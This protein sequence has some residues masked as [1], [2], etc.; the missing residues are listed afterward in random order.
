MFVAVSLSVGVA[1]LTSPKQDVT[2]LL[3]AADVE[4]YKAKDGR[5]PA[6]S[7]PWDFERKAG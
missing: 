3:T 6:P 4:L 1:E 2:D 7:S 5:P